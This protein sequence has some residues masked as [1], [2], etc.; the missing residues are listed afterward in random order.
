ME[1]PECDKKETEI[2]E[3]TEELKTLQY[4]LTRR[5]AKINRLERTRNGL[6]VALAI[7]GIFLIYFWIELC[8][9]GSGSFI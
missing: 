3:L 5:E 7:V 2:S 9:L 1:C 4:W 6:G 8:E